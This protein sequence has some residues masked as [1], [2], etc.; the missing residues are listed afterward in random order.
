MMSFKMSTKAIRYHTTVSH[1]PSQMQM[2][3]SL[4]LVTTTEM[5][6]SSNLG[7]D[8]LEMSGPPKL[9]IYFELV[10]PTQIQLVH[11]TISVVIPER[12]QIMVSR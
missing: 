2:Q 1:I 12:Q 8:V 4:T 3:T 11:S 5:C 9:E 7:L 6:V 10:P